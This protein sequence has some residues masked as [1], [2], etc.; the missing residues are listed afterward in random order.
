MNALE[1]E[2]DEK[3]ANADQEAINQESRDSKM[4]GKRPMPSSTFPV[5]EVVN[6]QTQIK[7]TQKIVKKEFEKFR[8]EILREKS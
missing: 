7:N 8:N 1:G 4:L 2:Q 6:E 5:G 3:V